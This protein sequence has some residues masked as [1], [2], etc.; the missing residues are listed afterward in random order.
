MVVEALHLLSSEFK[1]SLGIFLGLAEL[2]ESFV[3]CRD[4]GFTGR[5]LELQNVAIDELEWCATCGQVHPTIQSKFCNR[6]PFNPIILSIETESARYCSIS[7]FI[8]SVLPSV[9]G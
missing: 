4:F 3:S 6:E 9:C 7:V 8:H 1:C 2:T 5:H